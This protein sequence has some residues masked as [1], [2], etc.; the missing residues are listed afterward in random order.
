MIK[1]IGRSLLIWTMVVTS[2]SLIAGVRLGWWFDIGEVRII[3]VLPFT[4]D[5]V[6]LLFSPFLSQGGINDI[7]QVATPG[8][9]VVAEKIKSR[10]INSHKKNTPPGGKEGTWYWQ[11]VGENVEPWFVFEKPEIHT[12]LILGANLL[13]SPVLRPDSIFRYESADFSDC[14]YVPPMGHCLLASEYT[15]RPLREDFTKYLCE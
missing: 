13:N 7:M 9:I 6:Q 14:D 11:P 10:R 4:P 8:V 1:I 2:T 12:Y 3:K 15:I 5:S